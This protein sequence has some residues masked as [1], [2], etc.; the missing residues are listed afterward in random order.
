MGYV[1]L[2]SDRDFNKE[3]K[4]VSDETDVTGRTTGEGTRERSHGNVNDRGDGP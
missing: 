2:V 1:R 3:E 4:G